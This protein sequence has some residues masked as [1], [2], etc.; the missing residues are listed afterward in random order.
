[1]VTNMA[2]EWSHWASRE[3]IDAI[4]SGFGWPVSGWWPHGGLVRKPGWSERVDFPTEGPT[5]GH[6]RWRGIERLAGS[7]TWTRK[8]RDTAVSH[9]SAE[10]PCCFTVCPMCPSRWWIWAP[11][12]HWGLSPWTWGIHE[13]PDLGK[14]P[15]AGE[16]RVPVACTRLPWSWGPSGQLG[17]SPLQSLGLLR[18][19]GA[20]GLGG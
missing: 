9:R 13:A 20:P 10:R 1:V 8:C 7:L 14:L 18:Q 17:S 15:W 11:W 3:A 16:V 5:L 6:P 19:E 12:V 4:W 2:G